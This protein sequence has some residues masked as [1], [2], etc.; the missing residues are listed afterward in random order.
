MGIDCRSAGRGRGAN[1]TL[2]HQSGTEMVIPE[3][4]LK[5][6]WEQ[7]GCLGMIG[8]GYILKEKKKE[9]VDR[10]AVG[11]EKKI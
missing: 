11:F 7:W 8:F 1:G 2:E 5:A 9:F 4:G 6:G 10:L 3:R